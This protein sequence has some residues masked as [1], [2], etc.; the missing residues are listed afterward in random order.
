MFKL[1]LVI[2]IGSGVTFWGEG[3]WELL[4]MEPRVLPRLWAVSMLI[5]HIASPRCSHWL[6][7]LKFLP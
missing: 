5:K 3:K 7:C 6:R 4:R 2:E 1:L